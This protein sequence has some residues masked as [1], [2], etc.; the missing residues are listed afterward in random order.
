VLELV[1]RAGHVDFQPAFLFQSA[2]D[3]LTVHGL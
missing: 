2:D 3:G 1:M